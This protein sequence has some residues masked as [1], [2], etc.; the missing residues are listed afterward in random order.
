M[1]TAAAL[2]RARATLARMSAVLK[3]V[4]PDSRYQRRDGNAP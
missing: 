3:T 1:K 4:L 2:A